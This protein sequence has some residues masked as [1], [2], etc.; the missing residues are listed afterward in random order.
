MQLEH[1]QQLRHLDEQLDGL[2][3]RFS[4]HLEIYANNGKE[5]S[6]LGD[7]IDSHIMEQKKMMED[8]SHII[9]F[10]RSFKATSKMTQITFK[11]IMKTIGILLITGS[12]Y[13]MVKTIL[14]K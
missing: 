13:L 7:L 5:L 12:L 11:G 4:N 3:A 8:L 14:H 10:Y 6:R 9:E 2:E 1:T